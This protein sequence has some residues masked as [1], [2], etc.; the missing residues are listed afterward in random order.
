MGSCRV[1][2]LLTLAGLGMAV[3]QQSLSGAVV[4]MDGAY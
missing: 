3:A 4:S 1:G 2:V